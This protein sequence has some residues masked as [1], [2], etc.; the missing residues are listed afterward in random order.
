M[1]AIGCAPNEFDSVEQA[2]IKNNILPYYQPCSGG[3]QTT[4]SPSPTSVPS[5]SPTFIPTSSPTPTPQPV[6]HSITGI[7][8]VD[9][10]NNGV[11]DPGDQGY[12]GLNVSIQGPIYA[13]T[14][15][16]SSG[17]Y[18]FINVPAGNYSLQASDKRL[19]ISFSLNN[20]SILQNTLTQTMNFPIPAYALNTPTPTPIST[21]SLTPSPTPFAILS[22]TPSPQSYPSAA[23]YTCV[24][25]PSCITGQSSIQICPLKCTPNP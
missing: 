7:A 24:F 5:S 21:T 11:Q 12:Q 25:D 16:D 10:N 9:N 15:T 20:L 1:S 19:A 23:T 2:W 6:V 22:P 14:T 4:N 8:F 3:S 18:A 13:T 17:R